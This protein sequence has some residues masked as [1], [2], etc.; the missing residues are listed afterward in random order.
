MAEKVVI[1]TNELMPRSYGG[2]LVLGILLIILGF[3]AIWASAFTTLFSIFLLGMV[4]L[5]GGVVEFFY[6]FTARHV[7][8]FFIDMLLAFLYGLAGLFLIFNPVAGAY[9]VTFIIA[10]FLVI[11]GVFKIITP[12]FTRTEGAIWLV[13]SGVISAILGILILRHWNYSALVILGFFI[14]LEL[15]VTGFTWVALSFTQRRTSF[16]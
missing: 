12:I 7:G 3:I 8:G 1:D 11:T 2:Y 6:A 15:I 5:I 16:A 13:L 10:F 14:G 9:T 4:L